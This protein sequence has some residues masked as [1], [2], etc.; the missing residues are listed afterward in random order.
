M[1]TPVEWSENHANI[2]ESAG[3]VKGFVATG[4]GR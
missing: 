2:V 3:L 1:N 4:R